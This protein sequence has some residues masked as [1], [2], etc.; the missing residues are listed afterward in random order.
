LVAQSARDASHGDG[1][2]TIVEREELNR[3]RRENLQPKLERE[4]FSK[5]AAWFGDEHDPTAGFRLASEHQSDHPSA[6]MCRL[7]GFSS[8]G[9]C[10]D[11]AAAVA[12]SVPDIA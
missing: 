7:V 6:R 10:V 2:L 11:E 9:C 4:I 5:V 1:G 8:S 3:L 12:T